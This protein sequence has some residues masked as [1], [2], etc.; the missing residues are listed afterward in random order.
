MTPMSRWA[1]GMP[2]SLASRMAIRWSCDPTSGELTAQLKVDRRF[3]RGLVFIPEN[4][5]ALRLNSLMRR[6]EYPCPVDVQRRARQ[7]R[8]PLLPE[9]GAGA[10][11]LGQDTA[12]RSP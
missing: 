8:S 4:Y 9:L 2:R 5:R 12:G 1:R 11:I 10:E 3:P 6:G 7:S